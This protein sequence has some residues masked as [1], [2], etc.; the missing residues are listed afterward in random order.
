[1]ATQKE[2]LAERHK[3]VA[4]QLISAMEKEGLGWVK[5]WQDAPPPINAASS[6]SYN[7][8]NRLLLSFVA[9]QEGFNDPR[10]A[11]YRQIK[12][13]GWHIEKGTKSPVNVEFWSPYIDTKPYGGTSFSTVSD[14]KKQV[15]KGKL[16]P[17]VLKAKKHLR[18]RF[19]PVFNGSQIKGI[20]PYE[21]P[22]FE[23][24]DEK[25]ATLIDE[26]QA[27][28]RC[29]IEEKLQD[30]AF[31]SLGKDSIT[32]PQRTQF[33]SLDGFVRTQLHEM[34]HSTMKP[35][36][37]DVHLEKTGGRAF[38][39]LVAELGSA[40]CAQD[41]GLNMERLA[42]SA[43]GQSFLDDHAAYLKGWSQALREDPDV[44][45]R[46]ATKASAAS[47]YLFENWKREHER[48]Q[49]REYVATENESLRAQLDSDGDGLSDE[50]ELRVGSDPFAADTD[51]DG[52]TDGDEVRR[53]MNPVDPTP[54]RASEILAVATETH[55]RKRDWVDE[56]VDRLDEEE[57]KH[58]AAIHR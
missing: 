15:E 27:S 16:P 30:R 20:D 28:S 52:I 3:Q 4:D 47:D 32:M 6:K 18:V 24:T 2:I 54:P 1:M 48:E 26:L 38:E 11:T 5:T 19:Y 46:A 41:I 42:N 10:W 51:G 14:V 9:E 39:E 58:Q 7:G 35:L 36:E 44:L 22:H 12:K 13:A 33:Y 43:L 53:G 31:Y 45:S 25:L 57:R 23:H 56:E 8:I 55:K 49:E 34:T 17:E 50:E 29:P 21:A 40:F 37:R